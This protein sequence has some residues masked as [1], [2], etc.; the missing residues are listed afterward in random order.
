MDDG[1][2]IRRLITALWLLML[3]MLC[4]GSALAQTPVFGFANGIGGSAGDEPGSI[5]V[6][7]NGNSYVTGRFHRTV[8]F[9][10]GTGT[11]ILTASD[12]NDIYVAKYDASSNYV[13]AFQLRANNGTRSVRVDASGNVY[14]IVGYDGS[15]GHDGSNAYPASVDF[16]PGSGT[17]NLTTT[18]GMVVAKY[19]ANGAYV[20]A[21][22]IDGAM[23]GGYYDLDGN[24]NILI[25][26]TFSTKVD[27]DPSSHKANLT[28]SYTSTYVAKYSS[29]GSYLWAFQIPGNVGGFMPGVVGESIA[30]DPSNNIILAG[31]IEGTGSVD[32]NPG[33]GTA[34]MSGPGHFIAKYTSSGAYLWSFRLAE[35]AG[36]LIQ[37]GDVQVAV[38]GNG[39]I[40]VSGKFYGTVDFDPGSGTANLTSV[41]STSSGFNL[42]L[43]KYTSSGGYLWA[44]NIGAANGGT[45]ASS[46]RFDGGGDLYIGGSYTGTPD[47]NPG[48]GTA[49]L[50]DTGGFVARYTSSGGYVWA[51]QISGPQVGCTA[52]AID[53]SGSVYVHG[54]FSGTSDFDP[55]SGTA[56]LTP[57]GLRDVF[58]AKYTQSTLP[59]RASEESVTSGQSI[60]LHVAPNPFTDQIHIRCSGASTPSQV[61]IIDMIGRVVETRDIDDAGQQ[62]TLGSEL[63]AGAYVVQITQGEERRK[64][65]IHKVK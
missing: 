43:A 48:A 34:S 11:A 7:G 25:T 29:S 46:V 64:V 20:W 53:G 26:G 30:I 33:S 52:L 35:S 4:S 22:K 5:A 16:N 57:V 63:P 21:F 28:P 24:G 41:A 31:R 50:T 62:I 45:A 60:Q 39:N 49:A 55:R 6:D 38:D 12:T 17:A 15:A 47:F 32:L 1:S 13:W 27:F 59:K 10:P 65:M 2:T 54:S 58:I 56:S 8:D 19:T 14:V 61:Q 37:R 18:V 42:F 36:T 9:D 23:P 51:F 3:T 40:A 44:F